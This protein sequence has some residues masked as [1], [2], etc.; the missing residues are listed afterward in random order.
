MA[1]AF[2][3]SKRSVRLPEMKGRQLGNSKA[4]ASGEALARFAAG[5][6]GSKSVRTSQRSA[7]LLRSLNAMISA[8][9]TPT[10]RNWLWLYSLPARRSLDLKKNPEAC[11]NHSDNKRVGLGSDPALSG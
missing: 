5:R 4:F 6:L 3:C 11:Q 1:T 10:Q 9:S 7:I 8:M 2:A